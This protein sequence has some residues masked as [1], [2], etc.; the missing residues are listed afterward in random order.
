M[1]ETMPETYPLLC[2]DSVSRAIRSGRQTQDR[3]PVTPRTCVAADADRMLSRAAWEHIDM[4]S[5]TLNGGRLYACRPPLVSV[6]I[7]RPRIEAGDL[8]Y[9]REA[10]ALAD[11]G[12]AWR[13]DFADA[14]ELADSGLRWRPSIHMRK[15]DARTVLRVKRVWLER[16][17]A[18]SPEDAVSEGFE[19]AAGFLAYMRG[20]YGEDVD[21]RWVVACAFEVASLSGWDGVEVSP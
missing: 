12:L 16:C 20:A 15:A 13:A 14:H 2:S 5:A 8:L 10:W 4:D 1:T 17:G 7:I 19:D 21:A 11:F 18:I 9:V 3:R 6:D